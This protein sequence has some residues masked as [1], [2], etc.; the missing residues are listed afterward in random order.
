METY[1][2]SDFARAGI[3]EKFVQDNHSRTE[4]GV[5]RGLHYQ[6]NATAQGTLVRVLQGEVFDVVVDIR[7]GSP[8]YGKWVSNLISD[9][10][11]QMIYI[12]PGCA[13]GFYTISD[14]SEILYKM[15]VEYSLEHEAGIVW[16]DPIVGVKWPTTNPTLSF[17]D[18]RLPSLVRSDNDFT[19]YEGTP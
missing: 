17:K 2:Y 9:D 1:K 13:H 3:A 7:I 12:P 16:N 10:S 18:T 14:K 11:K 15:T 5:I 4:N 19:Y 8:T 6:K